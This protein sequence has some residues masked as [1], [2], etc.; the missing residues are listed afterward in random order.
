MP[1]SVGFLLKQRSKFLSLALVILLCS[2]LILL[3]CGFGGSSSSGRIPTVKHVFL[4]VEENAGFDSVITNNGMP[5]LSSLASQ[6]GL[7][8]NYFANTHPSIGNYFMM[9]TGQI[10]TNDDHYNGTVNV[11]NLV[12]Q[13]KKDGK[14]WRSYAE[15]LPHVGYTGGNRGAYLRRHN[16]LSFFSD[17]VGNSNQSNN[18]RPFSDFAGDLQ[19]GNLP[20]FVY[21]VPNARNDAHDCPSGGSGCSEADKLSAGDAWLKTNIAP[22]LSSPAFKDSVLIITFDEA[23]TSDKAH[24]GGRIATVLIGDQIK[25]GSKGTQLYQHQNLL[26]TIGR[27]LGLSSIPG[28]GASAAPMAEFFK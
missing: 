19:S 3:A 10:V 7:A 18:L 27:M 23:A 20:D 2:V 21:I 8:T 14:T 6:Y 9:A 24:G 11:N 4:L 1:K 25:P 15:S 22:L 28:D 12:R 5:Y 26:N 13:F 16:P 17:V